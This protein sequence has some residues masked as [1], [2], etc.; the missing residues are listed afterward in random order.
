MADCTFLWNEN[1]VKYKT[2]SSLS[3]VTQSYYATT[4]Y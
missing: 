3:D 2:T 1:D 4:F